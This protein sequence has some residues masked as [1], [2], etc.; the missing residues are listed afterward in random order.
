M[1]LY[2]K[3]IL[4]ESLTMFTTA[5]GLV[6]ALAWNEAVKALISRFVPKGQDILSLFIYALIVTLLAVLLSSRIGK[7]K[8]QLDE[9]N[10]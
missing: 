10:N 7:L 9:K 3:K 5:M 6:A 8:E 1:A 2:H 4:V